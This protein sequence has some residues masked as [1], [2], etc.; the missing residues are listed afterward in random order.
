MHIYTPPPPASCAPCLV[1]GFLCDGPIALRRLEL[2]LTLRQL[3]LELSYASLLQSRADNE[4]RS[5]PLQSHEHKAGSLPGKTGS[6]SATYCAGKKEP[7]HTALS[8]ICTKYV[9]CQ[10]S[11]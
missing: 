3:R 2:L 4:S 1:Q 5:S 8:P 10:A 11:L 9:V 7:C 6:F